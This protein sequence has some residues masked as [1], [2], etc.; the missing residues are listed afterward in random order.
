MKKIHIK[1]P[2]KAKQSSAQPL[3]IRLLVRF[4]IVYRFMRVKL[5]VHYTPDY[6]IWQIFFVNY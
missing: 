6:L 3:D 1:K 2:K 4:S 5:A